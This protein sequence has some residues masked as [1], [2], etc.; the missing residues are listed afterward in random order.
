MSEDAIIAFVLRDKRVEW[1]ALQ[2]RKHRSEIVLQKSVDLEW[3]EA[4]SDHRSP[5]AAAFLKTKVPPFKGRLGIVVPSDRVLMRIIELPAV[6]HDELLGMAEL[7]VDKFSPFP[8]DQMS[9]AIEIL[10]QSADTSRVLIAAV[11]HEY[12]EHLGE[13][14]MKAG[15]YPQSVDVDVLGWWTLIRDEG[16]VR[17][18]GQEI[19]VMYDDH[20]AQLI[21]VRDGIPV[22][23]RALDTELD[24]HQPA[25]AGE[26]AEE[27]EYTLMTLE[28]LW[29]SQQ[30][31]ALTLWVH[32][33]ASAE[34]L[35][36]LREHCTF[37]VNSA[38][39]LNLPPL[40]EGLSRRMNSAESATLDLAPPAWRK[41]IQSKRFQ[42]QA[43]LISASAFGGWVILMLLLFILTNQ[44][45]KRLVRAQNDMVR[46]QSEVQEVTDLKGQVN[47]LEQYADRTYSGLEC[48]REITERLPPGVD[49]TSIT[50]NK[51]AQINLRGEAD[52]DNPIYDF[53]KQLEGSSLFK[54]V[55]TEGINTQVRGGKNRSLFRITMTL[56][57]TVSDGGGGS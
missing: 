8:S 3:P 17:Q 48:L 20:C 16:K 57:S 24:V 49:I 31:S 45:K 53:I 15:L 35:D 52:T 42:R 47:S 21:V 23:I 37:E 43:A 39:L 34:V 22:M 27:L 51:T 18:E 46:L 26:I 50:Y 12:I 11:Q 10:H 54:E 1:T 56:P 30:T 9:L 55:K 33:E 13:F 40:S 7:Q 5:E 41:G 2:R 29:G 44:Q 19:L 6:N 32:G 25:F 14:L 38:N 4:V 28:G 36:A